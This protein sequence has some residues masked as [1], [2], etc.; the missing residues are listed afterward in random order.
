MRGRLTWIVAISVAACGGGEDGTDPPGTLIGKGKFRFDDGV[1]PALDV[2]YY[3]PRDATVDSPV[4]LALHGS[5]RD[6]EGLREDWVAKAEQYDVLVFAPEFTDTAF[7]GSSGY[8]LGNVFADGN[9]PVGQAPKPL[10]QWAFSV[11]EPL[12]DDILARTENRAQTYD[13]FG[14]S[15]GGQFLHRFVLF[16]PNAR[17]DRVVATNAGWYTV[18]DP[19]IGFPYGLANSPLEDDPP[20][21]FDRDLTIFLGEDDTDPNSAGLRHTP[22]ADAQ[23]LNRFERGNHFHSRSRALSTGAFEW[24]LETTPGV[25]HDQR[26]MSQRAADLLYR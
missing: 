3:V 14:H 25:A 12:F 10:E 24:N 18:P 21:W 2:Y 4:L 22:E 13:L 5:G 23:G 11:I 19:A 7:P 16:F 8:I 26:R 17:Y 6:A 1:V 9:D 20:L 15:A